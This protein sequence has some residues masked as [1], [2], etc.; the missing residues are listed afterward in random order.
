M[1]TLFDNN[2]IRSFTYPFVGGGVQCSLFDPDVF[3]EFRN[4][5]VRNIHVCVQLCDSEMLPKN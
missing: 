5:G 1:F 3:V 4:H 2:I